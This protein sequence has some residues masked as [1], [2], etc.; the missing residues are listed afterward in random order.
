MSTVQD[1]RAEAVREQAMAGLAA[2]LAAGRPLTFKEVALA[3]GVSERTLYRYYPTRDELLAAAFAWTNR[4]LDLDGRPTDA[5]SATELVRRAFVGFDE[6]AA[7][8]RELLAAPEGLAARLAEGPD[9]QRAATTLVETEAPGLDPTTR[10]RVA[11]AVQLLTSAAAWQGLRDHWGM[12]GTEA[13]ETAALA[14]DL[15]LAG[16]RQHLSTTTE[17]S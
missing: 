13:G 8:V 11:A 3:S 12:D 16:A 4:R 15:L 2:V 17:T 9:R 14:I 5:A 6:V 7:V 10:R 1:A